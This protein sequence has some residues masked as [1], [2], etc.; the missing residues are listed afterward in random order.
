MAAAIAATAGSGT[1]TAPVD[2]PALLHGGLPL[3]ATVRV[4][5]ADAA[6]PGV[7]Q[8]PP[9]G[10]EPGLGDLSVGDLSV[11]AANRGEPPVGIETANRSPAGESTATESMPG[12]I[13]QADLQ[14]RL[15]SEA[16]GTADAVGAYLADRSRA[17]RQAQEGPRVRLANE[18]HA[19]LLL[20]GTGW[21]CGSCHAHWITVW[22]PRQ[23]APLWDA[24]DG[25][26]TLVRPL[27]IQAGVAG[28][29]RSDALPQPD[30]PACC[31][32]I[33]LVRVLVWNGAT[34]IARPPDAVWSGPETRGQSILRP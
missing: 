20:T 10:S 32:Q 23:Q 11:A 17:L 16:I 1:T 4:V 19:T 5:H 33:R 28:F 30:E 13:M 27:D 15:E 9:G 3:A 12:I 34:F 26:D 31:P 2:A 6:L 24:D 22:D 7:Y 14:Q 25:I 18:D 29:A 8:A 21:G